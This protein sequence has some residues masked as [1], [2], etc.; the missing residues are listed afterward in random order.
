M[1]SW[2]WIAAIYLGLRYFGFF[3]L[4]VLLAVVL[5]GQWTARLVALAAQR[6]RFLAQ[7][8]AELANPADY[9]ARHQLG[10]IYL[11][12]R[13]YAKAAHYLEDALELMRK[14]PHAEPDP[15]LIM[16]CARVRFARRDFAGTAILADE[17]AQRHA[18]HR[19]GDANLLAGRAHAATGASNEALVHFEQAAERAPSSAEAAFRWARALAARGEGRRA[20]AVLRGFQTASAGAPAFVRRRDRWWRLAIVL[21]PA[22]RFLPLR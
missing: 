20:S 17:V 7:R 11:R 4:G 14:S 21:F 2:L 16:D 18:A 12:A 6:S 19:V 9:G 22:L 15:Q 1:S 13:R 5:L 3:G 10:T 8:R